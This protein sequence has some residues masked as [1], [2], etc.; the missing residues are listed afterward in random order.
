MR[1]RDRDTAH[2]SLDEVLRVSGEISA[3]GRPGWSA[4]TKS[5]RA[6][7]LHTRLRCPS[8]P[9]VAQ[10]AGSQAV[11]TSPEWCG[12]SHWLGRFATAHHQQSPVDIGKRKSFRQT[13]KLIPE[14]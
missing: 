7:C 14:R 6:H 3:S 8:M 2:H 13:K 9:C 5:W 1:P 4:I 10:S 11:D 12:M